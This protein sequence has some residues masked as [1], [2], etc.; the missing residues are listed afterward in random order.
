MSFFHLSEPVWVY[1]SIPIAA[2][3]VGY[4]TKIV[5]IWMMFNPI[6]FKGVA[7]PWLG[8][9]GQIPRRA[10]KMAAISVD[11]LQTNLLK[12]DELIDQIDIDEL[13]NEIQV[14][15]EE[16]LNDIIEEI[17]ARYQPGLWNVLPD[18]AKRALVGRIRRQTPQI[19]RRLMDEFRVNLDQLFDMKHTVVSTL[20]EERASSA[21]CSRRWAATSSSSSA[22]RVC[23]SASSSGWCR[24][25]R[26]WPRVST[27]CCRCSG[28]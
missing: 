25:S 28:C 22:R 15:L 21:N 18:M 24:W 14:P 5:M 16:S 7:E 17:A 8:W 10:A 20:V 1:V 12:P 23:T 11:T 27:C 9:Q 3:I 4:L 26:S 19:T 2:A 13:I 6:E